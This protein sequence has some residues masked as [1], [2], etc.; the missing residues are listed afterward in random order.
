MERLCKCH[1]VPMVSNGA[2]P[3]CV[4]K[5]KISHARAEAKYE[6][7]EKGKANLRKYQRSEKGRATHK[8]YTDSDHGKQAK[9]ESNKRRIMCG[10]TILGFAAT[11]ELAKQ[12]NDHAKRRLHEFKSRLKTGT[13]TE[14]LAAGR[15]QTQAELRED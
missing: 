8:R 11:V 7:S 3:T 14:S 2:N 1:G 12:I 6:R 10:R 5:R 9:R 13:K 15:V 4:V